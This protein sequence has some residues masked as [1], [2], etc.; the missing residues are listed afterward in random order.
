MQHQLQQATVDKYVINPLKSFI[1]NS[2]MGGI[3]LLGAAIIAIILANSPWSESYLGFW[4]NRIS[5]GFIDTVFLDYDLYHWIN[6]GLIS[7]FL[8]VLGLELKRELV[9][10]QLSGFRN[11]ILPIVV[12]ISGMIFPALIF[13]LFNG[14]DAEVINGWGIPM[15]CDIAFVLGILYLLGDKV[16][17]SVK[18]FLPLLGLWMILELS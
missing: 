10:G 3:V 6:D 7:I 9:D 17:V 2:V 5:I 18:I 14:S 12:G 1:S 4:K 16:P 11:A 13:F 8:F 15:A